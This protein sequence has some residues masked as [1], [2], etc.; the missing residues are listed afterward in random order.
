MAAKNRYVH[1]IEAVFAAYYKPGLTKFAFVRGDIERF[2]KQLKVKLP[3]NLGDIVYSFR[4]RTS[5]PESVTNQAPEGKQWVI[6]P[7]GTGRYMFRAEGVIEFQPN[8]N[9]ARTKV[10]DS[11]PGVIS[12]YSLTDE[13]AL[14]AKLRYNRLIDIFTRVTCYSL[15]NHLRTTVS[16]MGQVETDEIYV[17]LDRNGV[18][19]VLPVQ[20]KG[21]KDKLSVVQIEQDMTMCAQKL[22]GLLCRSIS[23]Q[24]LPN[25]II[26]LV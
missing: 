10:P 2:V 24:F 4:Y 14:L 23:A 19:Y 6:L 7:A 21:K 15:Q 25:D 11:T 5:L 8:P 22:P 20:A 13:Q 9:L 12:M 1:L 18:H 26:V 17:G 3:K 16:N